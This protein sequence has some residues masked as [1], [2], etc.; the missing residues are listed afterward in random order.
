MMIALT[1]FINLSTCAA[2]KAEPDFFKSSLFPSR[3]MPFELSD[4][5]AKIAKPC[6]EVME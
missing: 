4:S 6:S 2:V 3:Q 5:F 1:V